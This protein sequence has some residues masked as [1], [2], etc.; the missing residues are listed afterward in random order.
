MQLDDNAIVTEDGKRSDMSN[1]VTNEERVWYF[2]D[3]EINFVTV[4]DGNTNVLC[5]SAG[6]P[7]YRDLSRASWHNDWGTVL[8]SYDRQKFHLLAFDPVGCGKSL[9][10]NR[11]KFMEEER[12]KQIGLH[13]RDAEIANLIMQ[14]KDTHSANPVNCQHLFSDGSDNKEEDGNGPVFDNG[15]E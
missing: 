7:D 3:H 15:K 12:T 5:L 11:A 8:E 4:G 9:H 13:E 1:S 2:E 6:T 10:P 14:V